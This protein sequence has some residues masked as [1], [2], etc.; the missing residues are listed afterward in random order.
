MTM[1]RFSII[2]VLALELGLFA[3]G[4]Q[5]SKQFKAM[6]EEIKSIE[7]KINEVA[8]CDE[9]QVLNF[10]ILG[11]RSDVDNY[12]QE[13]EMSDTEIEQ[14]DGMIDQLEA[15]W[16][17]KWGAMECDQNIT[18]GDFDTPGEEE[19]DYNIL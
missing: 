9:L 18:D 19:F 1:N 10:A 2:A 7:T 17:G 5:S 15:T 14:L 12:R 4:D 3:C 16:N 13:S 8:D 6:E 11:L